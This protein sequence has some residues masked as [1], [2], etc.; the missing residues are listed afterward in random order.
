M[1][2]RKTPAEEAHWQCLRKEFQ[3]RG[4]VAT[5]KLSLKVKGAREEAEREKAGASRARGCLFCGK[6]DE[7]GLLLHLEVRQQ[8]RARRSRALQGRGESKRVF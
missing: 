3:T 6:R 5:E 7:A 1:V 4:E 2:L 8:A